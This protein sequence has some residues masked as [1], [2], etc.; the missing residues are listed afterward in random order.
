MKDSRGTVTAP[1][2]RHPSDRKKMAVVDGGKHAV[3]EYEV[4][5]DLSCFSLLRVLL[6]TGRTHQIRVHLSSVRHPVFGDPTYGGRRI[7]YGNVTGR[8]KAFVNDMLA[9][10]PRQALHAGTLGFIHPT[11]RDKVVFSADP[12]E[13]MLELLRR[14]RQY[15]N[16]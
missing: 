1:L 14:I 5:E 16:G 12:P 13:D 7:H 6:Q 3:T 8:Y 4:L 2:A 11:S 10:F 9:F 15:M